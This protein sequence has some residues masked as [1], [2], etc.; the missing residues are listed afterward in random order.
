MKNGAVAVQAF[1]STLKDMRPDAK[2]A[3]ERK[4][5]KEQVGNWIQLQ[6]DDNHRRTTSEQFVG[7]RAGRRDLVQFEAVEN[8]GADTFVVSGQFLITGEHYGALEDEQQALIK[9]LGLVAAPVPGLG[10]AVYTLDATP[11]SISGIRNRTA[12]VGKQLVAAGVPVRHSY[13]TPLGMVRK[14]QGGP[15]NSSWAQQKPAVAV[16]G[17]RVAVVDTGVSTEQRADGWLNGLLRNDNVDLLDVIPQP[18]D[19]R[20]DLGA[21]HGSFVAG[22]VQQVAPGADL[23]VYQALDTD[24]AA[25]ETTV[26]AAIVTA[27]QD[28]A[29]ILNLSF[30]TDTLEVDPPLSLR[31]AIEQAIAIDNEVLIVCAAGNTGDTRQVW[32]ASFRTDFPNNVVS[33]AALGIDETTGKVAGADWST[34]GN[35]TCSTL[36]EG[37]VSTYVI[38]TESHAADQQGPDTFGPESWATWSGTSFAAPQ[39]V[40]AVTK[41]MQDPQHSGKTPLE[42]LGVVLQKATSI[43]D[44]G[45]AIVILPA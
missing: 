22:V 26:A 28:G 24:G 45:K 30:G 20:L 38:G 6:H 32:P 8:K 1:D 16:S 18:T 25:A 17:P 13:V 21:G 9:K 34:H 11:E 37:V 10:K 4:R 40:G 43:T 33:V 36:G 41:V 42:A 7:R 35:V 44:Y 39:V 12:S 14:A 15:E 27:V 29:K 19:N 23:R 2:R 5:V 31:V 3:D